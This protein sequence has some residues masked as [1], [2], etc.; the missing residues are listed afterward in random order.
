LIVRVTARHVDP[1]VASVSDAM[2]RHVV[3]CHEQTSVAEAASLMAR[4]KVRRLAVLDRDRE[5]V[6][7]F[8]LADLARMDDS[9]RYAAAATM[10]AISEPTNTAKRPAGED[11]TGGRARGSPAGTL[12][13]Y[14]R[15][16]RKRRG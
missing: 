10:R 13:V 2:T 15:K 6:G 12:H 8:S 7:V 16:P 11:P 3:S 9:G 1:A 14:A 5:L 4:E